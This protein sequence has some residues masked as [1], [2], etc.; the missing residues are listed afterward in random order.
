MY[1][2]GDI[3]RKAAI[4]Y[5]DHEAIVFE[6]VRLTYRQLNNRVNRLANALI[7][8]GIG[9]EDRLSVLAENTHKYL[10]IYFAAG[11]LGI[12]VT[13]LNFRLADQEIVH[14][15]NDAEAAFLFAGDGYE[16]RAWGMKDRLPNIKR[17]ISLD[18]P[19]K[20]F[21]GYEDLL[22]GALDREPG[23][24]ASP[25]DLAVLMYTG[26]TTGL[27]KGVMLSHRAIMNGT[28]SAALGFAF[29]R[30]DA[31][32]FVLPLF[33]VSF[34]PALAVLLVGGKVVINRRP[35]L[36]GILKLIQ[37]EK[38]THINAVPTLYGWLLQFADVDAYDLSS[39]RSISYAGSPFPPDLLKRCIKKFGLLFEQIYAM[40]ECMGGT[41]L[42]PEDHVLEG[43]RS[44]LLASAGRPSL[45]VDLAVLDDDDRPLGAGEIGEI[46]LRGGCLMTGYWKNPELTARTLRGGW[47]HTGDMGCLDEDGYLF[48]VD[49]KADMIVTG[50]E[51]VYPKETE[52]ALY[53]H[54]AVA[55][56]AVVSAPDEKWGERVQ[57]VVTL[58]AGQAVAE[59]ELIAHCKARLAGYKC[60]KSVAFWDRIPTTA[61]GKILRKDVKKAFWEGHGRSVG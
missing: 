9:P 43:E 33:H 54:P 5:P 20:G 35:D 11:K 48:L 26:G 40:T 4:L 55:M 1:T 61:V 29:S 15:V 30:K 47:H 28:V 17:W 38:C 13:P 7:G 46:A 39:L 50:G 14:I 57:A 60:P 41:F 10:E 37:D 16:E 42:L 2:L 19:V 32:C 21:E 49:R 3:P 34:W 44:R 27:P 12:S 36:N 53:E 52:D 8:L 22:G 59:E 56:A 6:G 51:N 24:D 18:N 25:E 45:S 23:R 58:K 31:T